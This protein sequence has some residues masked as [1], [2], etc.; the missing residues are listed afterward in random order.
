[1]SVSF[2]L[3]WGGGGSIKSIL[4]NAQNGLPW[5]QNCRGRAARCQSFVSFPVLFGT[6]PTALGHGD[7][8]TDTLVLAGTE[9]TVEQKAAGAG[10]GGRLTLLEGGG[11]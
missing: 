6:S 5:Q 9:N 4:Q 2:T 1:M 8:M 7:P 3:F 10:R 11:V